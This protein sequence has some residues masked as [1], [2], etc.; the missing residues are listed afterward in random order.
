MLVA[1]LV[2][3][4]DAGAV[5]AAH[6]GHMTAPTQI[7]R[8]TG[9]AALL[10]AL[11]LA[12]PAHAT[13]AFRQADFA[14]HTGPSAVAL[15]DFN[16]D[17]RNDLAV[18]NGGSNDVSV[19]LGTGHG[20]FGPPTNFAAHTN[21]QGIAVGDFN[22]DNRQD[23]AVANNGSHDISVL[24]GTGGG[25]FGAATNVNVN[26]NP[27]V[28]AAGNFNGC[29][30]DLAIGYDGSDTLTALRST[31]T[32]WE[33][34]PPET[35]VGGVRS[36]AI[37]NLDGGGDDVIVATG[38]EVVVMAS[39][40]LTPAHLSAHLNPAAVSA[41]DLNRDGRPDLAVANE[42]SQ[43]VSVLLGAGPATF[44]APVNIPVTG[45]AS[46]VAAGRLSD[47]ALPDLVV[48]EDVLVG[49]GTGA[50]T[51]SASLGGLLELGDVAVGDVNGDGAD[52]LVGAT[53]GVAR[54]L[55]DAPAV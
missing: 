44:G 49:D 34:R 39:S 30:D 40:A 32:G 4:H 9:P 36:I 41:A 43:D 29:T 48:G 12:A 54:V 45:S 24:H 27:R 17:G 5:R 38:H 28:I 52:D 25:T 22:G 15:G 21:P 26:A 13:V 16:A 14:A 20:T 51:H 7:L 1:M 46:T 6:C 33:A 8:A 11:A 31:P 3:P 2:V 50:F 35:N 37:T 42:G 10:A 55:I 53:S 18:A 19:L 47:D 23:L